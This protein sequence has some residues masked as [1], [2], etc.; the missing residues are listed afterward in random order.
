MTLQ[1][2]AQAPTGMLL[3]I[4]RRMPLEMFIGSFLFIDGMWAFLNE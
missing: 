4:L 3:F 2:L 1:C